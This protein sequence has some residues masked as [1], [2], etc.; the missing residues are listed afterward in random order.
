MTS[1]YKRVN[2]AVRPAKNIER[3]MIVEACARLRSFG[4]LAEFRYIGL[5]STFFSDFTLMHRGLHIENMIS[6]ERDT[7]IAERFEF[8]K[9]YDCIQMGWGDSDSVLPSLP[10]RDIPTIIW[11]DYDGALSSSILGDVNHIV[12]HISPG[13]FVI[14]TVN[15]NA[16]KLGSEPSD[17]QVQLERAVSGK[18]PPGLEPIDFAANTYHRVVKRILYNEVARSI[19]DRNGARTRNKYR[20]EPVLLFSY[21]DGASML[22]IGGVL[23]QQS[24][25]PLFESCRFQELEFF[26]AGDEPFRIETPVITLKERRKLD[27]GLPLGTPAC[28]GLSSDDAKKYAAIYRYFPTFAEAEL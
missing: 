9:P 23:C 11:M 18:V 25:I 15:A 27:A 26:R 19:A 16:A 5:G 13:S 7:A 24:Q 10:W 2:F 6:I 14:I 8:N 28:P 4:N 1:S 20:F 22:T 3:K 12:A 21:K 17:R